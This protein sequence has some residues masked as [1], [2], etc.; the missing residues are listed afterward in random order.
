MR[1]IDYRSFINALNW[2]LHNQIFKSTIT[3]LSIV[4]KKSTNELAE[5]V[6]WEMLGKGT[7]VCHREI[8]KASP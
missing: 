5:Y 1:E 6:T 7:S 8:L 3:K 4:K 2:E